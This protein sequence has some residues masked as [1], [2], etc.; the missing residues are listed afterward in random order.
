[1]SK[2][3]LPNFGGKCLYLLLMGNDKPKVITE[4]EFLTQGGRLFLSGIVPDYPDRKV[5][6]EGCRCA[7]AWDQVQAYMVFDSLEDL[8]NRWKSKE[9]GKTQN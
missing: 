9:A 1:M 3:D 4:P 6:A 7:L 2:S 5:W 8:W